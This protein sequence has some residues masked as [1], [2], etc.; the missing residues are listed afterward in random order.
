SRAARVSRRGASSSTSR[1]RMDSLQ[2]WWGTR[3]VQTAYSVVVAACTRIGRRRLRVIHV[4]ADPALVVDHLDPADRAAVV[5]DPLGADD[6]AA[7]ASLDPADAVGQ[8]VRLLAALLPGLARAL[9]LR[10]R[11]RRRRLAL[12][13]G[14]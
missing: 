11:L 8:R 9:A 1:I 7:G 13:L 3:S 12:D 5:G 4:D 6:L 2:W 14:L 10:T